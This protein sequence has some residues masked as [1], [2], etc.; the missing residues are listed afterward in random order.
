MTESHSRFNVWIHEG[1]PSALVMKEYLV[2]AAGPGEVI[3]PPTFAPPE[4]DKSVGPGYIVDGEGER[5]SVYWIQSDRR[6]IE[7]SLFSRQRSTVYWF[8]S[9]KSLS[10]NGR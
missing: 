6:Q 1:G 9:S 5:V 4:D 3:F 10:M 2:P 8:P 7:W